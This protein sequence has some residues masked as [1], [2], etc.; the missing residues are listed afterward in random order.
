M[1]LLLADR[2]DAIEQRPARLGGMAPVVGGPVA[3]GPSL[4][5][6]RRRWL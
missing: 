4:G 2:V 5:R 6:R 3:G 1:L